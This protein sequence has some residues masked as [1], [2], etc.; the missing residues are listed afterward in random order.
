[1]CAQENGPVSLFV[2]LS[3]AAISV[4]LN[5]RRPS[6]SVFTSRDGRHRCRVNRVAP[7]PIWTLYVPTIISTTNLHLH[8]DDCCA[9]THT[10]GIYP[11][12]VHCMCCTHYFCSFHYNLLIGYTNTYNIGKKNLQTLIVL[13][14]QPIT[15]LPG[16]LLV[17]YH[18]ADGCFEKS[19]KI[20][21][22]LPI[23]KQQTDKFSYN[24]VR[25]M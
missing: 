9:V 25:S 18:V 16:Y 20:F 4:L 23:H 15:L 10:R 13:I 17:S 5:C 19:L 14:L 12:S 1:M 8:Q 7:S 21:F 6:C 24:L 11:F 2:C 3:R 22:V